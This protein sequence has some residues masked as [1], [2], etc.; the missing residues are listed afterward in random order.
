MATERILVTVKTYPTLSKKYGETVCTAG[1]REDGSWVRLYPVPFRRLNDVE[2]YRKFDWLECDLIKS[3]SDARP[4]SFHPTEAKQLLAVDHINTSDNWRIRRE[5]L[6][7]TSV[8]YTKLQDLIDG[9]KSNAMSL[10]TFK[11]ARIIDFVWEEEKR[12]WDMQKVEEMR[13]HSRQGVLFKQDAWRQTFN[14]I[15][16]LPYSFSYKFEDHDGRSSEMQVLDWEVG[17][18]F[19]NC[20]NQCGNNEEAALAKVK[21]K[22]YDEFIQKD[23]HFFLGTTQQFHSWALNPWVV[24]GV[25]PIPHESQIALF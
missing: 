11:P 25:F 16:K 12:A 4:E 13:N 19:W 7:Q 6:L 21:E 22:Y 5:L 24:V 18:L 10:A 9:A 15:A 2:Q 8:V 3:K 17:Q 20:M 14:L 23:L 1:V